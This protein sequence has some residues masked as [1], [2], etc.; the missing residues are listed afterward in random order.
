[1]RDYLTLGPTPA[2]E[3]CAQLGE[4]TYNRRTRIETTVYIRQLIRQFGDPP[5]LDH[6]KVK[7]FSHEFGVYHEVVITYSDDSD[8]SIEFAFHVEANLPARWDEQALAEL[9]EL[10]YHLSVVKQPEA[11]ASEHQGQMRAS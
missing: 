7:G 1:M 5:G 10:N 6:F 2:E 9:R 3:P 4:P 8:E 11:P